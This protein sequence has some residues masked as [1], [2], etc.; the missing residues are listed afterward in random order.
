MSEEPAYLISTTL[1]T[2]MLPASSSAFLQID[3]K[4]V[5]KKPLR[6]VKEGDTVLFHAKCIDTT[7]EQIEPALEQ[8][9]RYTTAR[10]ALHVVSSGKRITKLR[11]DLI[12][13]LAPECKLSV[14]TLEDKL[15]QRNADFTDEEYKSL[16]S[17]LRE[18]IHHSTDEKDT[19]NIETIKNWLRGETIAPEEWTV[20]DQLETAFEH[21]RAWNKPPDEGGLKEHYKLYIT[22]RKG[23]QRYLA[24]KGASQKTTKERK[25]TN[26]PHISLDQE[27]QLVINMFVD[28]VTEE[29]K[30]ARITS[31]RK[32]SGKEEDKTVQLT[33]PQRTMS[34]PGI[35]TTLDTTQTIECLSL[36]DIELDRHILEL[37]WTG[38]LT[39]FVN[40]KRRSDDLRVLLDT[41]K[42]DERNLLRTE[43]LSS[44]I[45]LTD[46]PTLKRCWPTTYFSQTTYQRYSPIANHVYA[47]LTTNKVDSPFNL[48]CGTAIHTAR[49]LGR[50]YRNQPP[51]LRRAQRVS[52]EEIEL[53]R[54][55]SD[56]SITDKERKRF[57]ELRIERGNNERILKVN[58]DLDINKDPRWFIEEL[59]RAYPNEPYSAL[60][61]QPEFIRTVVEKHLS[62]ARPNDRP[63]I[64]RGDV[65]R[66][67][68]RY[69]L[70]SIEQFI[71][72]A[73]FIYND[74]KTE[75]T[76][77]IVSSGS[78]PE[79]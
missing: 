33:Q 2:C 32:I 71:P 37:T 3:G 41:A 55:N 36:S 65:R 26:G 15:F 53:E 10:D 74:M 60:I 42:A 49:T 11:Y 79:S 59:S 45:L 27:I 6:D 17:T 14:E 31:I 29:Y 13:A 46:D 67:L 56:R 63:F 69:N 47:L 40:K 30:A 51:E 20:F 72:S 58:Y 5:R 35:V 54:K 21:F 52:P 43:I 8:S 66:T 75:K 9:T 24:T 70:C 25:T 34:P 12:T 78:Q 48:P 50:L 19:Y 73:E 22:V 7:L 64:C 1:G 4:T 18:K 77:N 38:I 39:T 61:Q 16:A 68:T 44:Y 28:D 62:I 57:R 23:V 76:C